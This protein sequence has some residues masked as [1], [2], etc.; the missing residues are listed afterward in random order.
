MKS[1][2]KMLSGISQK[3]FNSDLAWSFLFGIMIGSIATQIIVANP[4]WR[5]RRQFGLEITAAL[6]SHQNAPMVAA[7]EPDRPHLFELLNKDEYPSDLRSERTM[8][9]HNSSSPFKGPPN[10]GVDEAWSA[11]WKV[12]TFSIDEEAFKAS[13]PQH[14]EAGVQI[15]QKLGGDSSETP[16]FLATFEATHQLHCLYNLF[17]ASYLDE[18]TDEKL[19]YDANPAEWH[20]RVDHC[21]DVLRQKLACW[22]NG[23]K[24]PVANFNVQR[25]CRRWENL[26]EWA[27]EHEVKSMPT[28]PESAVQLDGFP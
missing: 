16:R 5:T 21:V 22:V 10:K 11:Y 13:N 15:D 28:K 12:W 14:A 19:D 26:D 23:K 25:V 18:Y 20:Q 9:T 27:A 1:Y 7:N 24:S 17:R 8:G 3:K 2:M 4:D 6:A